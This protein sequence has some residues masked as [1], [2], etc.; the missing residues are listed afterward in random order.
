MNVSMGRL[1]T[2]IVAMR[3]SVESVHIYIYIYICMSFPVYTGTCAMLA[4]CCNGHCTHMDECVGL[5]DAKLDL[6]SIL[7]VIYV[8]RIT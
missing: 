2:A 5:A 6:A 1:L 8:M 3:R 7:Q 4:S